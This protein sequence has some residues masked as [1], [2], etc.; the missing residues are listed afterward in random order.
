MT[1]TYIKRLSEGES[2]HKAELEM[3]EKAL[4]EH[5]GLD[6]TG[7]EIIKGEHG[8]P[9]F[10]EGYP[11]FNFSNSGG[12]AACAVSDVPVGVDI[13][14]VR[15]VSDAVMD[16]FLGG[17]RGDRSE[18]TAIWTRYESMG[19]CTGEGIPHSL[20]E[21]DFVFTEEFIGSVSLSVCTKSEKSA[22][23]LVDIYN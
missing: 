17:A 18:R 10:A 22:I 14:V 7:L 2:A 3:L 21:K 8:K 12:Y 15:D 19:K 9:Y 5:Y 23:Y 4:K 16:R 20:C 11:H 6:M 13:E 1:Y